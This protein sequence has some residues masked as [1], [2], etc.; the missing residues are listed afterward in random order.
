MM[1]QGTKVAIL[2]YGTRLQ[3]S[4]KAAE[5]LN[6][7]GLST[8]VADARFAKPLDEELIRRLAVEHEVLITI[9]EGAIGGFAAQVQQFLLQ[10]GLLDRGQLRLRSMFLPDRFID[11][12]T[13]AGMYEEAELNAKHIAALARLTL[14]PTANVE[15]LRARA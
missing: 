14:D 7:M 3:E 2:S 4:M 1:R 13:P 6:A 9:E 10:A 11:H 8:S 15:Q 12:G 5:E